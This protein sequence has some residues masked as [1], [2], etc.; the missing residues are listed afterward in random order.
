MNVIQLKCQECNG[1]M[2]IDENKQ[3]L[4]CP[5]CGS[6]KIIVESDSV[7]IE[8]MRTRVEL[9]QQQVDIGQQQ[10]ELSKQEYSERMKKR[11]SRDNIFYIILLF[12]FVVI[13]LMFAV[14]HGPL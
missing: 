14:L 4:L 5:Y 13:L 1:T 12:V 9:G 3:V 7:K 11:E 2:N 6:K 10:L 8:Q